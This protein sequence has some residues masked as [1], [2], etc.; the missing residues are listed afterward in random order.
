MFNPFTFWK[1][2]CLERSGQYLT[3]KDEQLVSI[4]PSSCLNTKPEFVLYNEFVL[5]TKNFIRT[6]TSINVEWLIQIAP[7]FFNIND[8][9]FPNGAAKRA[10]ERVVQMQQHKARSTTKSK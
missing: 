5:T 3:V 10:I 9:N 1:I 7:H 4:H 8:S 2:F 6:V